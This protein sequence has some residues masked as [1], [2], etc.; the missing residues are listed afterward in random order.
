MSRL[1]QVQSAV[2]RYLTVESLV[3]EPRKLSHQTE[4]NLFY[5]SIEKT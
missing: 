5:E 1:S 4:D 3:F 2:G